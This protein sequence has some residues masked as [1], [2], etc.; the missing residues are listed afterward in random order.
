MRKNHSNMP[1]LG[2]LGGGQLARMIA[3][4]AFRLGMK[5]AIYEGK[6]PS[7][8]RDISPL[9]FTGAWDDEAQL[10]QFA[11][12]SDIIT[13]E[14]EF[15]PAKT[16]AFLESF[17]LP[18]YPSAK[19]VG[20]IQDKFIQKSTL[21]THNVP[22]APFAEVNS[23]EDAQMCG[24]KFGYPFL[25]KTRT[26]GYDGYGNRTV[27]SEQDIPKALAEL[28]FPNQALYAEG[29][30]DFEHELATMVV[31]RKNG[32]MEVY[33]VVETIQENHICKYVIAPAR[34]SSTLIDEA[35]SL[36]RNAIEHVDGVGIF[37]VEMFLDTDANILVNELAPRPHNSGHYTMEACNISQFSNLLHAIFDW[38]I[39]NT[40]MN[41][42]AAVMVNVLGK[43]NGPVTLENIDFNQIP[44][45][46]NLHIYGKSDCRV[47]RKMGHLT[48]RGNSVTE[49]LTLAQLLE[50]QVEL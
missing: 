1:T 41:V 23:Q 16:L 18:V 11:E 32:E 33:P 4:A 25:M 5:V 22:V 39:G 45:I 21:K 31:R 47:G 3:Y 35:V 38:K 6:K 46:A 10:A 50:S 36:A 37:G 14:N 24:K 12:A 34:I 27:R 26:D 48:V 7:P 42:P 40:Q 49:C 13:L 20:K 30:I 17:G 29:F 43:R 9:V 15:V 19:T 28:G 44:P 2:I 8:C